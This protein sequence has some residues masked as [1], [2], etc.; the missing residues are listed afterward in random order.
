MTV[1]PKVVFETTTYKVVLDP[2]TDQ[3]GNP[4]HNYE[5]VNKLYDVV[6]YTCMS[7]PQAIETAKMYEAYL[8]PEETPQAE[9]FMEYEKVVQ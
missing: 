1:A 6:E 7:L 9:L 8:Q 2:M 3:C 4:E 5:L